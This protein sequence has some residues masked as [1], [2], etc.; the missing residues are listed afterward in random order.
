MTSR[1]AA[2]S[3]HCRDYTQQLIRNTARTF[4]DNVE[5]IAPDASL[6]LRKID[7]GSVMQRYLST[8]S[9]V[10]MKR[11]HIASIP[12]IVVGF[13]GATSA[14]ANDP[15]DPFSLG[16]GSPSIG[17]EVWR[18]GTPRIPPVTTRARVVA[19]LREAQRLGLVNSGGEGDIKVATPEQQHSITLAGTRAVEHEAMALR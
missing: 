10:T 13:I 3:K 5:M 6:A 7:R 8:K 14:S 4:G 15:Y 12:F 16:K 19:E 18:F 2:I 9:G 17:Q 1:I 11:A